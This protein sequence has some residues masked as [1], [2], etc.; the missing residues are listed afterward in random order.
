MFFKNKIKIG[1]RVRCLYNIEASNGYEYQTIN[2]LGTVMV[3]EDGEYGIKFDDYIF[4]DAD[5]L[6]DYDS[7]IDHLRSDGIGSDR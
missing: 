4:Q 3:K 6:V 1:D 5:T 2:K 7:M